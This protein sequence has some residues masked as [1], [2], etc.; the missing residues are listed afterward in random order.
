MKVSKYI[1]SFFIL[2]LT[3]AASGVKAQVSYDLQAPL[4]VNEGERFRIAFVL[5]NG[6]DVKDFAQPKF[7]NADVL[8][9]PTTA[10]GTSY[11]NINGVSSATITRSYTYVLQAKSGKI[12]VGSSS[13]VASGKTYKTAST[14]I[15][16]GAAAPAGSGG[17][18]YQG[19]PTGAAT[20]AS[21]DILLRLDVS[22]TQAYKGEALSATLSIYTR[23][24]ISNLESAKY[25]DF[26]GFWSQEL[27]VSQNERSRASVSGKSYE[28]IPL[29]RWL[30]FPQRTGEM[31]I[32]SSSF[33]AIA[34]LVTRANG[35]SLFD[36]FFGNN[37]NVEHRR[38]KITS[39]KVKITVL[40]TPEGSPASF[41]GAV[42]EFTME[43]SISSNSLSA[44]SAGSIIV[45]LSGKGNFPLI[46]VPSIEM[47]AGIELYDTKTE[48]KLQNTT[49]GTSGIRTWE[50]PFVTRAEGDYTIPAV[51]IS[52]FD[53][54]TKSYKTLTSGDFNMTVTRDQ[55]GSSGETTGGA[56]ISGVTRENLKVL[57][58]DIRF[59]MV[60]DPE[61]TSGASAM[62]FSVW[63]WF[64]VLALIVAF[65]VALRVLRGMIVK[66][67]DVARTKNKKANKVAL[68]RLRK[69]R[70]VMAAGRKEVFFEEMLRA[71]WGYVGDKLSIEVSELTRERVRVEL[72]HR[73]VHTDQS[74]MFLELIAQC[75]M[76]QYAPSVAV[77]M[78]EAYQTALEIIGAMELK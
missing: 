23:V 16:V 62:V 77:P 9:G 14:T 73:G 5:T 68:R 6:E 56:F 42:G 67:E 40:P 55:G 22:K 50:F 49:G 12:T 8:A 46:G 41:D 63:Y 35:N 17:S 13:I 30:I 64:V 71:L 69:A 34:Q 4:S 76:A 32:E 44:N 74:D 45:K 25:S 1:L 38:V 36:D 75:E 58:R 51:T 19:R 29:R 11:S 26:S 70:G 15:E 59:I 65:F 10:T 28:V 27:K 48:D 2:L 60:G 66:R 18:S 3:F 21:D 20:M 24:G 53:P 57:G 7:T 54:A 31:T 47:P 43:S 37:N 72:T 52:Y 33:D 61:L 39:P 78:E